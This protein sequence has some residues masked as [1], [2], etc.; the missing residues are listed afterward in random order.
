MKFI[1]LLLLLNFHKDI[2]VENMHLYYG[3]QPEQ[4]TS[5]MLLWLLLIRCFILLLIRFLQQFQFMAENFFRS[6]S[7]GTPVTVSH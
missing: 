5:R 1:S 4:N 6:V 7:T 2:R 3:I